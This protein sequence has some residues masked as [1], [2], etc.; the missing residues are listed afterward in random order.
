L[1][2]SAL[3]ALSGGV[4]EPGTLLLTLSALSLL[5]GGVRRR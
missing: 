4:P 3:L 5:M 2:T 1:D